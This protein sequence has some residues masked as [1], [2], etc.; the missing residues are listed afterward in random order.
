M[1]QRRASIPN[2]ATGQAADAPGST[3]MLHIAKTCMLSSSK[4]NP[5]G[6]TSTD[7]R[8]IRASHVD[9]EHDSTPPRARHR[10]RKLRQRRAPVVESRGGQPGN[11]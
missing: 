5:R 10:G 4:L 7:P 8:A 9:L 6:G 3:T 11:N 2:D 1:T